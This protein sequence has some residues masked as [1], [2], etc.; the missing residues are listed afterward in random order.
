MSVKKNDMELFMTGK[1][2]SEA[3]KLKLYAPDGT[4]TEH[5]LMLIGI[6]SKVMRRKKKDLFTEVA[7]NIKEKTFDADMQDKFSLDLLSTAVTGWS[8]KE[9]CTFDK[10]REFLDNSP[11]IL[12][13]VDVFI[14]ESENYF[15]KK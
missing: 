4:E 10:V 1:Q 11:S 15:E 5:Y 12:E 7:S 9:E 3:K 8:F 6:D 14:N 2:H 13:A